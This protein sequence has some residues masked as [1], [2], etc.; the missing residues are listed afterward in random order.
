MA[1]FDREFIAAPDD[2]KNHLVY[3]WPDLN[4]RRYTRVIVNA[5][6]VALFVKTGAVVATIGPGRHRVDADELPVL[7]TLIDALTG[8]NYYRAEL[9]FIARREVSG[10]KF[11]G[12]LAEVLDP[13]SQQVVTLRVYGEFALQVRDPAE[14]VTTCAGTVDLADGGA[15]QAWSANLLLK[16]MKV[17]VTQGVSNGDW[18]LLGL[19]ARLPEIE[20]A[21]VRQTNVALYEYGL[22]IPRLGNF[23][24]TPAPE[25]A[26][27]LKRLAKDVRYIHLTGDFQRYAAG[28]L[29]LGAGHG[30]ARGGEGGFLSAALGLHAAGHGTS[31]VAP[32]SGCPSCRAEIPA[33]ARFCSH[34]GTQL[35]PLGP[36]GCAKCH[37]PLPA[38]AK[39]CA[40]CGAPTSG[41]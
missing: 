22:R 7:G 19:S 14:F 11:G 38:A 15:V 24:I 5:D 31:R 34:C 3:K 33:D 20:S 37:A 10:H 6:Q 2:R 13:V 12:Y 39:F 30:M 21:V 35:S 23:D 1:W 29:A 18:P 36:Q 9:Y 32:T 16:A 28:E 8:G 25:D 27:R 4:I 17:V 26:E 40:E 41:G